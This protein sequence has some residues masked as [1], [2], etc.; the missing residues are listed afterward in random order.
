MTICVVWHR[1]PYRTAGFIDHNRVN[2]QGEIDGET[3]L[4]LAAY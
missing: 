3:F 1:N 2:S 4:S